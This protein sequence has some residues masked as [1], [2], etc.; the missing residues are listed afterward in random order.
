M[1][2]NY[3]KRQT[4]LLL[5]GSV[6][7]IPK[8]FVL[9]YGSGATYSTTNALIN[10]SYIQNLTSTDTTSIYKI[11]FQGDWNS[12]QISG[13]NLTEFAITSGTSVTGSIWS[14]SSM[15]A[16]QFDGTNELQVQETWEVF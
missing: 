2:V 8:Q 7:E 9:G 13:L 14:R 10:G 12:S 1:I 5:G 6:V 15:P 11:K 4:A 16:I 3:G